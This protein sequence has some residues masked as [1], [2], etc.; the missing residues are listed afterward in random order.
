MNLHRHRW[1]DTRINA[2]GIIT[3]QRCQCGQYRHHTVADLTGV[4]MGGDLP[5]HSGRHPRAASAASEAPRSAAPAP[6]SA[7]ESSGGPHP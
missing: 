5:W 7:S 3:E 1:R 2:F 4:P 6:A